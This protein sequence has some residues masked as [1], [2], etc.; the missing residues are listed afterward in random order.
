MAAFAPF[1][2]FL[3]RSSSRIGVRSL[4][5]AILPAYGSIF[6]IGSDN[7]QRGIWR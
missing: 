2:A 6:W 1:R 5:D 4:A 7:R 3:R